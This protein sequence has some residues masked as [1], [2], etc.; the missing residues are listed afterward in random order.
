VTPRLPS[1]ITIGHLT[2]GLRALSRKP[3][4]R[5]L[6]TIDRT[7]LESIERRLAQA[8]TR[9][10]T[11][12]IERDGYPTST[13]GNGVR[14]STPGSRTETAA[15][16]RPQRD[17]HHELTMF[18]V[19]SLTEAVTALTRLSS[20]LNS[21]DDLTADTRPT[22]RTC[23]HCTGKRG[24]DADLPVWR[25]GTVGNRLPNNI[26]LCSP[27]F[28]FV[29]QTALAGSLTGYLPTDEQIRDHETRGR[30][31]IRTLRIVG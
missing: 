25:R 13:L 19:V 22:P 5:T 6:A 27:C 16:S 20:A 10:R 29:E 17:T 30:W 12:R 2:D 7:L 26:D 8:A 9:D 28:H 21:L 18:A 23:S 3:R 24:S 31:R 14:S 4:D 11:G 1:D 15:L